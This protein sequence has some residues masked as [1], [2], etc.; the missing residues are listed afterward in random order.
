MYFGYA[1]VGRDIIQVSGVADSNLFFPEIDFWE[2]YKGFSKIKKK[3][4]DYY[5]LFGYKR[6]DGLIFENDAMLKRAKSILGENK[7]YVYIKPSIFISEENVKI[8]LPP[9][10][11]SKEVRGLLLCGWQRNK[12]ILKI[13]EIAAELMRRGVIYTF[14]ITTKEDNSEICKEFKRLVEKYQIQERIFLIGRVKKEQFKSLYE[15]VDHVF[16][17]SKLESFSNNIIEAW[18]FKKPLILSDEIWSRAICHNAG[19]YVDRDSTESIISGIE[20]LEDEF[21]TKEII[22]QG[23]LELQT[24]PPIKEKTKK[25]INYVKNIVRMHKNEPGHN[26]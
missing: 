9:R 4:I 25:E 20:K 23:A 18:Y 12:N 16:M 22:C 6:A 26:L 10:I 1:F 5:R 15:Q 8:K 3:V 14:I 11:S 21:L 24:Y 17:L 19:V 7:S 2:G 13:P